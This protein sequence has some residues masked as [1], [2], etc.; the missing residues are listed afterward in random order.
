MDIDL[1]LSCIVCVLLLFFITVISH[2][3]Q[4]E[5]SFVFCGE[6]FQGTLLSVRYNDSNELLAVK[7][8]GD[9][10]VSGECLRCLLK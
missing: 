5:Q 7:V 3:M 6:L 4:N 9:F 8:T 10:K 1:D 2:Y